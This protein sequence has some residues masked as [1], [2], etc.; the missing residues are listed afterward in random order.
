MQKCVALLLALAPCVLLASGISP[1]SGEETR[2]IKSLSAN[3]VEALRRGDGMGFAKP[4]ELNHF[5]GPK[6]VLA[7]ADKLELTPEQIAA[8]EA[9]YA[10][11]KKDAIDI[12]EQLLAA[13]L[14]LDQAFASESV[15]SQSLHAALLEIGTLRAQLRFVHLVAH[16]QQ[17]QLLTT[18]QNQKYGTVRGY[19]DAT[20]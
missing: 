8:T 13:E 15:S 6:H 11:M 4:A 16:L 20:H 7:M 18:Q 17:K 19:H 5:P 1:Y 12:G 3:E 9:L 2:A 10:A 14:R